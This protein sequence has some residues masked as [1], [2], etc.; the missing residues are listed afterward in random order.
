MWRPRYGA[1][2]IIKH[3]A[4]APTGLSVNTFE[5]HAV[6]EAGD[7]EA[8]A[9]AEATGERRLVGRSGRH[10]GRGRCARL[11]RVFFKNA[12]YE[13]IARKEH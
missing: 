9:D 5:L 6:V 8:L 2:A 3:A 11:K 7:D 1:K 4:P 13:V 12:L 10:V